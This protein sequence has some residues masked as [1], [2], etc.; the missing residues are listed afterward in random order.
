MNKKGGKST[1]NAWMTML[2]RMA[3]DVPVADAYNETKFVLMDCTKK[4][5]LLD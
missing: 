5:Y 1:K 3:W 2:E 4:K